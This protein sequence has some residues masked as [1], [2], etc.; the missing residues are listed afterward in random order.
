MGEIRTQRIIIEGSLAPRDEYELRRILGDFAS[1]RRIGV[2]F[3]PELPV[4]S[5]LHDAR[6]YTLDNFTT[7]ETV[8][9]FGQKTAG[10]VWNALGNASRREWPN[11]STS[12]SAHYFK[13]FHEAF[14]ASNPDGLVRYMPRSIMQTLSDNFKSP[15]DRIAVT[16]INEKR[17]EFIRKA[18]DMFQPMPS[19]T[20]DGLTG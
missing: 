5:Y 8:A 6:G 9:G 1:S 3:D 12:R 19:D 20:P 16:G 2:T 13:G 4:P 14:V 11:K 10:T 18:L 15:T 17:I 7:T